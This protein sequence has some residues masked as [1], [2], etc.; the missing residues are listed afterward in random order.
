MRCVQLLHRWQF[1]PAAHYTTRRYVAWLCPYAERSTHVS[2]EVST[3][4]P[5]RT[6]DLVRVGPVL[7]CQSHALGENGFGP[8]PDRKPFKAWEVIF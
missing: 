3:A 1:V 2:D 7:G 4:T 6:N 8:V 5:A